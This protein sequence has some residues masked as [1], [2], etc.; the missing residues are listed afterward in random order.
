MGSLLSDLVVSLLPVIPLGI[1]P[2]SSGCRVSCLAAWNH[3]QVGTVVCWVA[4]P[5]VN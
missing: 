3:V 4:D 2:L 1:S 5:D